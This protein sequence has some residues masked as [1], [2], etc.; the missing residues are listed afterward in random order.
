MNWDDERYVRLYTRQ[1]PTW[2]MM[3]WQGRAVFP[4]LLKA[5]DRAGVIELGDEGLVGLAALIGLPIEVVTPGIETLR[6]K[7]TVRV[8]A[9]AIVI[10]KFIEAQEVPISDAARKRAQR[11]RARDIAAQAEF[12]KSAG[13]VS[14]DVS[15]GVTPRPAES[16]PVTPRQDKPT[17]PTEP[18]L[19]AGTLSRPANEPPKPKGKKAEK[20]PDPRHAPTVARLTE[21]FAEVT[22][23]KYGFAPRDAKAV[24]SLLA[25][26]T[27]EEIFRRWRIGLTNAPGFYR[28]ATIHDLAER[29]NGLAAPTRPVG[30]TGP[31]KRADIA[32][33]DYSQ[34][35][36]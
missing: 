27:D 25:Y 19:F 9:H 22:G 13:V 18:D 3:A 29:W 1:T 11:E 15:R 16:Q 6:V 28:I 21:I 2:L 5:A 17:E 7:G 33:A 8:T 36:L 14:E 32:Q 23:H 26:G 35:T 34:E 24:T 30:A 20:P 4:L 10:P 12:L 31:P